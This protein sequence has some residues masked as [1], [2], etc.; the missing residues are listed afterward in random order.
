[1]GVRADVRRVLERLGIEV[2]G[3][4]GADL[5]A[6]CPYHEDRTPSWYIR[7]TGEKAGLH[8]CQACEAGGD[9]VELVQ[10]VR[11]YATAGA[12]IRWITEEGVTEADLVKQPGLRLEMVTGPKA[13]RLPAG[14]VV[15]EPLETWPAEPRRYVQGRGIEPWQVV[16]WGIGYAVEGR[17]RGRIVLPIA[18]ERG[19][20]FGYIARAYG[21]AEKRFLYPRNEEGG[22][23]GVMW[24]QQHWDT[25][26]RRTLVVT[27]GAIKSLA[28][29][30]VAPTG[31]SHAAI[32][33][34]RV[35][36]LQLMGMALFREVVIVTDC[37]EAGERAGE[38]LEGAL[39]RYTRVRR[40]RLGKGKDP[41]NI[42]PE[43]LREALWEGG[44]V[45][46]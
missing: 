39:G 22:D 25:S 21:L 20:L 32:G 38:V 46:S 31:T 23:R 2:V 30:R 7:E 43:E 40:V 14:T 28:V 4:S 26:N 17:L 18:D 33:G 10:H 15:G 36:P 41:D 19:K 3:R 37:D 11:G 24:G 16:R 35:T 8:H 45:R 12:A 1:M 9:L 27:E 13:M 42:G 5:K 6:R 29:E 34:A 44:P